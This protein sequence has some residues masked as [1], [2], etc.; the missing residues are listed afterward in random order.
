M[1]Y[2]LI[3]IIAMF[4]WG[5][6]WPISRISVGQATP[7]QVGFFRFLLAS[8]IYLVILL[9]TEKGRIFHKYSLRDMGKFAL[10]GALGV[11]GYG[12]IFLIAMQFTTSSQGAVIAGINPS[13]LAIF[14]FIL[15]KEQLTPKWRYFGLIFSFFG[16]FLII[17][18]QAFIDFNAQHL[19]GN[20]LVVAAMLFWVSYSLY[21]KK[22]MTTFSSLEVTTFS[23][24][25]GML[26]FGIGA[27]FENQ[28]ALVP[29]LPTDF[30]IGILV[31]G[32]GTTVIGFFGYFYAIKHIGAVRSGVFINLVPVFGTLSSIVLIAGD[33]IPWTLWI[34]LVF[35]SI[36]IFFINFPAKS[37]KTSNNQK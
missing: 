25:F 23:S 33:P 6:S 22:V 27:V 7:F 34:G 4:F 24:C 14:A 8:S 37:S 15:F 29:S 20:L 31:L 5:L 9:I 32:L 35:I 13:L 21:G 30:W 10:L 19:I 36:G 12:I 1:K 3:L 28:W 26:F 2:F 16:A 11:F 17:G 18:V